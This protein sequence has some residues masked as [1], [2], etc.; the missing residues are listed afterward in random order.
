M[1]LHSELP[2]DEQE[3]IRWLNGVSRSDLAVVVESVGRAA[4][5]RRWRRTAE[6][7]YGL[8]LCGAEFQR[9]AEL[10]QELLPSWQRAWLTWS[11]RTS[12]AALAR[13]LAEIGAALAP[14][15]LAS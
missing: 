14:D 11:G 1:L 12:D 9:A 5:A 8:R 4:L 10:C 13:R 6:V 2:L 3:M 15:G 7:L